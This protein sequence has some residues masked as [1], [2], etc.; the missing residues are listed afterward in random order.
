[1]GTIIIIAVYSVYAAF[2]IRFF[3]HTLAWWRAGTEDPVAVLPRRP[4]TF[5]TWLLTVRDVIRQRKIVT[6]IRCALQSSRRSE[7]DHENAQQGSNEQK[8]P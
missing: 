1:M 2:W 5:T 6:L 8:N 7:L 4:S 3:L